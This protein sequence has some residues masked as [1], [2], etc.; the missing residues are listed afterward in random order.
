MVKLI[1]TAHET[2][3]ALKRDKIFYPAIGATV[4]IFLL[5]SFI[6]EWSVDD[7]RI[8]FYNISTTM[9][10]LSGDMIALLF[11]SKVIHDAMVSGSIETSLSRPISRGRWVIGKYLGLGACLVL[12]A[13]IAGFGWSLINF[14]YQMK[15]PTNFILWGTLFALTEWLIIGALSMFLSTI[16]GFGTAL[17]SCFALWILGLLSG[18]VASSFYQEDAAPSFASE[19]VKFLSLVWNFDRFTLIHYSS[20]FSLPSQG[21]LLS[22]LGYGVCLAS[23]LMLVATFAISSRDVIR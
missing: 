9:F 16:A 4:F 2:F 23:T 15:L 11:G 13:V 1:A 21:F 8:V 6:A 3:L 14:I 5:A 12:F 17:F 18:I 7:G 10:R 19:I 22:S 20:T